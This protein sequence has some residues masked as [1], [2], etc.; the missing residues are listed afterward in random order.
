MTNNIK[1]YYDKL[2]CINIYLYIVLIIDRIDNDIN[3]KL[4]YDIGF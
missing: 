1:V 4:K 3:D 2:W